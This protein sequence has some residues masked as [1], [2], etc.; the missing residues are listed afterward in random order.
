MTATQSALKIFGCLWVKLALAN[1]L[2]VPWEDEMKHSLMISA[3]VVALG[4]G[5]AL[6]DGHMPF[7]EGEGAFNWA[8]YA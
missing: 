4:A 6:A 2:A 1:P 8:S 3:A 7:A 5:G